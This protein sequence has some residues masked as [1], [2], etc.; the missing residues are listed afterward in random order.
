MVELPCDVLAV[1][2]L[3][4]GGQRQLRGQ[5]ARQLPVDGGEERHGVCPP[6]FGQAQARH[7]TRRPP[8]ALAR[9]LGVELLRRRGELAGVDG[10][11]GDEEAELG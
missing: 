4:A 1:R 8:P 7:A 9:L 11:A 3:E 6:A 5:L 10:G 2:L